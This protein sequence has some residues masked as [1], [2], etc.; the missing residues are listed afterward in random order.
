VHDPLEKCFSDQEVKPVAL[1]FFLK[2]EL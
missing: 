1:Y 2:D